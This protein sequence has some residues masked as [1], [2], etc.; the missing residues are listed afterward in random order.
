MGVVISIGDYRERILKLMRDEDK[1]LTT[2][3]IEDK[4]GISRARICII[5]R[6]LEDSRLVYKNSMGRKQGYSWI[7]EWRAVLV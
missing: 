4:T 1:F 7:N 5:L 3:E 6:N 2:K